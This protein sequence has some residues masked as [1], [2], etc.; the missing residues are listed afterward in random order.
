MHRLRSFMIRILNLFRRSRLDA[1]L[2]QQFNAHREMIAADLSAR[3]I[4][5]A[6]A[7]KAAWRAVGNE[8]L[9]RDMSRDQ[10]VHRWIDNVVSDT[11]YTL[12]A[13]AG[14]PLFTLTVILT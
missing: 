10:M 13:L 4:D 6:E 14:T 12:R 8:P 1:D 9:L 2:A 3:G 5:R 11:R 7:E